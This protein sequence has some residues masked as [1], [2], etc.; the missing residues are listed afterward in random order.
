LAFQETLNNLAQDGEQE[1]GI[2]PPGLYRGVNKPIK[3]VVR[4][5]TVIYC[6]DDTPDGFVYIVAKAIDEQQQLLQW[7]HLN[8]SYNIHTVWNG[9]E[10]PL[11]PGAARYYKEKGYMK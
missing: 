1:H 10:V 11:H 6:R 7:S 5:G 3:T 4:T 9:Y 8:F 2:I